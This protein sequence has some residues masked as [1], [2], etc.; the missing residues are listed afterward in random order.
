MWPRRG[1]TCRLCSYVMRVTLSSEVRC[2]ALLRGVS[3]LYVTI[4]R[5]SCTAV[6]TV[7]GGSG[8]ITV[9]SQAL[10]LTWRAFCAPSGPLLVV[11]IGLL[12]VT[13][14]IYGCSYVKSC[15]PTSAHPRCTGPRCPRWG[16]RTA[17]CSCVMRVTPT[18]A[19]PAS[20]ADR[21][22][23][24]AYVTILRGTQHCS[25]YCPR[26]CGCDHGHALALDLTCD[27]YC[28]HPSS[29]GVGHPAAPWDTSAL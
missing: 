17:P 11:V 20:G 25:W 2:G 5:G 3:V 7:L 8:V 12:S 18:S 24:C 13:A 28:A 26:T 6:G 14:T 4:L 19:A 15:T 21:A 29:S 16:V 10:D 9:M 1:A 27:T 22:P 23:T